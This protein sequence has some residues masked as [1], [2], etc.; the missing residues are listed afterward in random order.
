[1]EL[2]LRERLRIVAA[3]AIIV[4]D[5]HAADDI[6][7]QVVL[8]ALEHR[9]QVRDADHLRAWGLRAARHR[10]IDFARKKQ[11]RSLSTELLDL[12]EAEWGDPAADSSPEVEALR[13]CVS[14]LCARSHHL[15]RMRY[16][17]GM[18]A[19][20]IANQLHRSA[21]AVYQSLSRIHR[22]L[23]ECVNQELARSAVATTE[24]RQS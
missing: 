5:I 10:A 4:R 9:T 14:K 13:G 3:A 1:M 15:L 6:F 22:A 16:F 18:P 17:D 23:R 8:S 7:Q 2:L 12:F 19:V 24:R 11:L 21:D 20:A